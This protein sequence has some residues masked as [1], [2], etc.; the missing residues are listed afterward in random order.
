LGALPLGPGARREA[1]GDPAERQ[2][3]REALLQRAESALAR[4]CNVDQEDIEALR[5]LRDGDPED[6]AV[7]KAYQDA[8]Q[9]PPNAAPPP[10]FRD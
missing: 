2:R 10:P 4:G 9:G 6:A 1:E 7:A 5:L 8:M 3:K